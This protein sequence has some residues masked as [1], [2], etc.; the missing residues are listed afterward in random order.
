MTADARQNSGQNGADVR[1]ERDLLGAVRVP[2]N[3]LA[4]IHAARAAANF[5]LA[6]RRTHAA[7]LHA[8]GAVKLACCRANRE[9]DHL[10]ADRAAAISQA[11]TEVME[12]VHDEALATDALQGGAGTSVNMVVN[13]VIA[14]RA[15]VL[16]GAQP[17]DRKRCHPHDHVNLHQ[18][19]NDTY[20]TALRIAA[21]RGCRTL[22][23]ATVRL[24]EAFQA[25]ERAAAQVVCLGRTELQDAVLLTMGR[26][27]GAYADAIGRDRWR[28]SKCEERLRVVNLGGTAIGTGLGAPR[29][30]I[31][32]VVEVLREITGLGLARAENLIDGTANADAFAEVSGIL[33]ALA[34]NLVK[35]ADD[36]RLLSSGP[37]GGLGELHLPER[38]EGSSIMPGK[39]NPV[40]P[41]SVVQA[42]LVAMGNHGV[43]V[44][45]CARGCL[46]LNP[47]LPLVADRLL[48]TLG[49]LTRACDSL[50]AR[51]VAGLRVDAD[52]CARHAQSVTAQATALAERLGHHR[53]GEL[54]Q[55]ALAEGWR[56]KDLAKQEGVADFDALVSP[57]AVLRLGRP[58]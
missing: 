35:I 4:G 2:V 49:V 19:T 32:R 21:I 42:G 13:E 10:D 5:D 52:A 57:A 28:I 27:F 50:A 55:K 39:V 25:Q 54:A 22:E 8:F 11:C 38:Q 56:L 51:C 30:Y 40:I 24:Q 34:V 41:E 45:A 12:G 31:F 33:D 9:L 17:G 47:F 53:A 48:D 46:E 3:G 44:Q 26:R 6:G 43:I 18:S 15:C 14:N 20:P 29:A 58:S 7:L 1:E 36:L 16:L 23:A 37:Q